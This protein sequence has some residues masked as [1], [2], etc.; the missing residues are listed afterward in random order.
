MI[1]DNHDCRFSK[2]TFYQEVTDQIWQRESINVIV[3]HYIV[4][5]IGQPILTGLTF[6]PSIYCKMKIAFWDAW[7]LMPKMTP[8]F[9]KQNNVI[10]PAEIT[11]KDYN[12]F[13]KLC[14]ILYSN[15][16]QF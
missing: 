11:E 9:A 15:E 16:K 1:W 8:I 6:F 13:E 7:K 10:V 2:H 3:F 4:L 5:H 14:I 12:L